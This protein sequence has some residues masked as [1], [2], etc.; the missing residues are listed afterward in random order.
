MFKKIICITSILVL[1][2]SQ[3]F[4]SIETEFND[5]DQSMNYKSTKKVMKWAGVDWWEFIKH[6]EKD[7]T[8]TYYV[9]MTITGH[10]M[11]KKMF[12]E[13]STMNIDGIDYTITKIPTPA[14]KYDKPNKGILTSNFDINK[15]LIPV[16]AQTKNSITITFNFSDGKKNITKVSD[17]NI[18]EIIKITTLTRDNFRDVKEGKFDKE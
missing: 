3:A 7:G 18:S 11:N 14:N 8:E 9:R 5:D 12:S 17:K 10:G 15:D 6:I 4:A 16:L 2:C 1:L 13:K